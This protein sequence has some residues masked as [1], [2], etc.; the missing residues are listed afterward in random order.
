MYLH[1]GVLLLIL[2]FNAFADTI[3]TV[4]QYNNKIDKTHDVLSKEVVDSS[5][6]LDT[7]LSTLFEHSEDNATLISE[8]KSVDSFFQSKK[9]TAE[10][11]ESYISIRLDSFL[12]SKEQNQFNARINA[13]I[14]L[15]RSQKK[16]NFFVKNIT[17]DVTN[18]LDPR[19][20]NDTQ[21]SPD[22]PEVGINYF[23][24]LFYKI[25]SKYLI[26]TRGLDPFVQ[27]RYNTI[28]KTGEWNIEPVQTFRY[29]LNEKF[30]E[31]TNL[32]FDKTLGKLSLFRI[33]LNRKT[34]TYLEGMD[35]EIAMRYY[36]SPKK[37]TGLNLSQS[38]SGNTEYKYQNKKFTHINNYAT[39]ISWRKNVLREWFFYQITPGINF[40]KQYDYQ[41]NYTLIFLFDIYFGKINE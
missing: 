37:N 12:Q 19:T 38:F 28:F 21:Y 8:E 2:C 36:Y 35:Y 4:P 13:Q 1:L 27:A 10:T 30:E 23:A 20:P 34:T 33:V 3:A 22:S 39:S 9:F 7:K 16:L 32:Y 15:V 25:S 18:N 14:P 40:H 41:A 6:T 11:D 17:Q 5:E 29:S 31:Q 24:P 26:G